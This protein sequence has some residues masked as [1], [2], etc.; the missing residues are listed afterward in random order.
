MTTFA[1]RLFAWILVVTTT[2]VA[3]ELQSTRE[4]GETLTIRPHPT[5]SQRQFVIEG[6]ES[7]G[8]A[9]VGV[10][11]IAKGKK[12]RLQTLHGP[13][14]YQGQIE[15]LEETRWRIEDLNFD[16]YLD[17]GLL[18]SKSDL[19]Y[20]WLFDPKTGRFVLNEP[21]GELPNLDVDK[22]RGVLRSHETHRFGYKEYR[23]RKGR[24][25]RTKYVSE[26]EGLRMNAE[27]R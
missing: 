20:Y 9:A 26:E 22:K 3:E 19:H 6:R 14:V 2:S 21:L 11:R 8:T 25:V 23:W 7:P 27:A 18:W 16:G 17:V 1:T 13:T 5:L 12:T 4:T 10:F 15:L 24:L